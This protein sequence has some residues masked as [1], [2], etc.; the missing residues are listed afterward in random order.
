MTAI[1]I[2]IAAL[3]FTL[4]SFWWQNWRSGQIVV[5]APRLYAAY[6]DKEKLIIEIPLVIYNSGPKPFLIENLQLELEGVSEPLYFVA[7]VA[8]LG[9]DEDRAF[10]TQFPLHGN[11]AQNLICEFQRY[12]KGFTFEAKEY[13]VKLN[14]LVNEKRDWKCLKMF[15]LCVSEKDLETINGKAFIVHENHKWYNVSAN[16]KL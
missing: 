9:T 1:I 2:S 3:T 14:A 13:K 15:T 12:P 6:V 10:A 16:E 5:G 11:K 7:T 4:Y 8:K